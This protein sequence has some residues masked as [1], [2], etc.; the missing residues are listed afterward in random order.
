MLVWLFGGLWV[1]WFGGFC[2]FVFVLGWLFVVLWGLWWGL[3]VCGCVCGGCGVGVWWVGLLGV[4]WLGW[5]GGCLFVFGLGLGWVGVG[6]F[7][8]LGFG[9][10][11]G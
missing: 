1:L 4:W 5:L 2:L 11:V 9:V 7:V 10:V 6:V 3:G 8:W